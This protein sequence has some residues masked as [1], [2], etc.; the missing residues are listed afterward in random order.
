MVDNI[1]NHNNTQTT[2]LTHLKIQNTQVDKRLCKLYKMTWFGTGK[3][4]G[5]VKLV[6]QSS[7]KSHT[8]KESLKIPKGIISRGKSQ[9]IQWHN[10]MT[11]DKKWSIKHCTEYRTEQ[12]EPHYKPDVNSCTPEGCQF[13]LNSFSKKTW[14]DCCQINI[15]T[16]YHG[17]DDKHKTWTAQKWSLNTPCQLKSSHERPFYWM[18]TI[19]LDISWVFE[20]ISISSHK[21]C[22][23]I[24][25]FQ[26]IHRW[27]KVVH[28]TIFEYVFTKYLKICVA[29]K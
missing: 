13:I 20:L 10:K 22:K 1:T 21:T 11:R 4:F 19:K 18:K 27:S 29:A 6:H 7:F 26:V 15:V 25:G 17:N 24:N 2:P 12:H 9:T 16:Q 23:E 5:G 8:C 28:R 3:T 14:T